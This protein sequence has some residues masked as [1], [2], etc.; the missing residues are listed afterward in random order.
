MDRPCAILNLLS[1]AR[2]LEEWGPIV[3]VLWDF[4][5]LLKYCDISRSKSPNTEQSCLLPAVPWSLGPQPRR[6]S[7]IFQRRNNSWSSQMLKYL[8]RLS[9]CYLSCWVPHALLLEVYGSIFCHIW[10]PSSG[11]KPAND[12][13]TVSRRISGNSRCVVFTMCY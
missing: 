10:D 13:L 6:L 7:E 1:L 3:F 11:T 12:L 2:F 9:I 8:S 4:Q 5:C